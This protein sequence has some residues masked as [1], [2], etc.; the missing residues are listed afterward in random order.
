MKT[1]S[2]A[3]LDR[4]LGDGSFWLPV[5]LV[6][7]AYQY[8]IPVFDEVLSA[9]PTPLPN[10]LNFKMRP[11]GIEIT[12]MHKFKRHHVGISFADLSAIELA[13]PGQILVQK[14]KS[15]IGRALLGGLLLGPVGALVG[16]VS[17]LQ[18]GVEAKATASLLTMHIKQGAEEHYFVASVEPKDHP[19][20]EAFLRKNLG[21]FM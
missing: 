9:D 1:I 15:V 11:T 13:T 19:K 10:P 8:G 12:M 2:A 7:L 20:T 17:G 16:S 21:K 3:D 4:L 14:D 5:Q 6:G 18:N